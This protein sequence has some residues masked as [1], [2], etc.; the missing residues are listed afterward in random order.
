[1]CLACVA[2]KAKCLMAAGSRPKK[3][4]VRTLESD[5][6]YSGV[7]ARLDRMEARL[8]R[9]ETKLDKLV[10]SM[11]WRMVRV[12]V[13]VEDVREWVAGELF[14]RDAEVEFEEESEVESGGEPQAAVGDPEELRE[15]VIAHAKKK[16]EEAERLEKE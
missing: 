7:K 10:S 8:E 1:M 5:D 11:K 4:Q 6:E 13:Q 14:A 9:M 12:L 3:K 2:K 15:E 16:A